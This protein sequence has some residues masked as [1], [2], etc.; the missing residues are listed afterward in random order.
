MT[1]FCDPTETRYLKAEWQART[2]VVTGLE[3]KTGADFLVSTLG[4]PIV[5]AETLAK[6][7][8]EGVLI[9]RKTVSDLVASIRDGRLTRS[10]YK[11]LQSGPMPWLVITGTLAIDS[12]TGNIDTGSVSGMNYM[13]YTGAL[14]WYQVRGGYVSYHPHGGPLMPW[15]LSWEKKLKAIRDQPEKKLV[16]R[17]PKQLLVGPDL[18]GMIA[19]IFPEIGPAKAQAVVDIAKEEQA[20]TDSPTLLNAMAILT[21]WKYVIKGVTPRIRRKIRQTFGLTGGPHEPHYRI[22]LEHVIPNV[23]LIGGTDDD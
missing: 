20:G 8:Q 10:L 19:A 3:E 7:C 4:L 23:Q 5:S 6:H 2:K 13:A 14:D 17:S 21:D 1:I 11:M 16:P 15:M 9:Q 18:V 22:A 12:M